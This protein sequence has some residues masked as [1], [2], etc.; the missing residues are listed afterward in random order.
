M[1]R[2]WVGSKWSSYFLLCRIPQEMNILFLVYLSLIYTW[3]CVANSMT[4]MSSSRWHFGRCCC[5]SEGQKHV[6][7]L[8]QF[9]KSE[10]RK[11]S[12]MVCGHRA[13]TR[14]KLWHLVTMIGLALS[15]HCLSPDANMLRQMSLPTEG[16]FGLPGRAQ[17]LDK[18]NCSSL[19]DQELFSLPKFNIKKNTSS[20]FSEK[21]FS[22]KETWKFKL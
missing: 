4:G 8:S 7:L 10:N 15:S 5:C 2:G 14:R 3:K 18:K 21:Y 17:V 19:K 12:A 20:I 11:R 16:Q 22:F 1:P 9:Q 6:F 13:D